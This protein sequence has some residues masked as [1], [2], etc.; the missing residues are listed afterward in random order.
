M[1]VYLSNWL[2]FYPMAFS[3][4]IVLRLSQASTDSRRASLGVL[5]V[6]S[7]IVLLFSFAL[8]SLGARFSV[9]SI[10]WIVI[11]AVFGTILYFKQR[12]LSRSAVTMTLLSCTDAS[13]IQRAADFFQQEHA[14][15]LGRRLG[16][17]LRQI[18]QGS[19]P[20][21]AMESTGFARTAYEKLTAR[22]THKYGSQSVLSS[23]LF[24]P[25]R[26]EQEFE[27]LLGRLTLLSWCVFIGPVFFLFQ[28]IIVP[29][30][31]RMLAEF[32]V[33]IPTLLLLVDGR[34]S[35]LGGLL[36]IGIPLLIMFV[37][38]FALLSWI[39]PAWAERWPLRWFCGA[40]FRSLGFIA[41]ARVAQRTSDAVT[42]LRQTAE[43]LPVP[44]LARKFEYAAVRM[45]SGESMTDAMANAE[46]I[47]PHQLGNFG[48]QLN[49]AGLAWATEQLATA[50]IERMLY[51]YSIL[52][53]WTLVGV[54]LIFGGLVA[55][56]SI[57]MMQALTQMIQSMSY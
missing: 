6:R 3:L 29:T 11:A 50:D 51:R 23:E 17:F 44:Y 12:Q 5:A 26:V 33:P 38:S 35:Y 27:R 1:M 10:M 48:S 53:Q 14:G 4:F 42:A 28:V 41:F 43:L 55:A 49:T 30:L 25:L 9:L 57:G 47:P 40:Y 22:L 16:K 31:L 56:V 19:E 45:E 34:S 18:A 54:T 20:I 7:I 2:I 36:A 32:A 24:A 15:W 13:Q 8:V 39:F 37:F 46:L 21:H 52:I